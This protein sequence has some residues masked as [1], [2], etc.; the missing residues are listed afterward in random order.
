MRLLTRFILSCGITLPLAA[1]VG[2]YAGL[3]VVK[4]LGI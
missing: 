1:L 3:A 4:A 2:I